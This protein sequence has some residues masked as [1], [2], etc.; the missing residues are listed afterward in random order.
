MRLEEGLDTG[1]VLATRRV[2]IG[3]REHA[4]ALIERLA[5]MGAEILVDALAGGIDAL[6][7]GAPQVG[8]PTYAPK[9]LPE[10]LRL[11][12]ARPAT[13]LER[14]VRLD[15][16]WTTFRGERLR[17]LDATARAAPFPSPSAPALSDVPGSGDVPP[18]TLS[19]T[20]V[21]TGDGVLELIEVQ[22]A[23]KRPVPA[24]AWWRGVR[25]EPGESLGGEEERR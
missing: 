18:G 23:G 9:I 24:A 19:G 20:S 10:E 15:R 14:V 22:S 8:E 13:E 25:P 2:P 3:A 16:A 11:H 1:P 6:P 7:A 12:W 21:V 5:S 4:S 17:V